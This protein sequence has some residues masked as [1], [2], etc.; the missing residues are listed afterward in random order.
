MNR[1]GKSLAAATAMALSAVA[2]IA[3]AD[4]SQLRAEIDDLRAQIAEMR[5]EMKA[6]A[7]QGK[8]P[9]SSTAA[10]PPPSGTPPPLTT[11]SAP[12]PS[13]TAP[14]TPAVDL[15][16]RVDKLEQS[17]AKAPPRESDTTLFSYGEIGY[18]R[19][20]H[21]ANDTQADLVRAVIGFGHR[22][23]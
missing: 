3:N 21:D 8:P 18:S 22:F 11:A 1:I 19:P 6:L 14:T 9:S 20:R 13:S 23:D 10:T 17:A 16:A 12:P 7:E 5:A 15:A 4:E 2:P